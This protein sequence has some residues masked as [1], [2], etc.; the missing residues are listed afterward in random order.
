[1]THAQCSTLNNSRRM[2]KRGPRL[3]ISA[4]PW[5]EAQRLL[6]QYRIT[7]QQIADAAGVPLN[8]A[9]RAL[10][11]ASCGR[12]QYAHVVRV[13]AAAERLLRESG[14]HTA[15]DLWI[16]YDTSLTQGAAA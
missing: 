16:A 4:R 2:G 1:M 11:V 3:P 15:C 8:T 9:N 13:R 5:T 10:N 14:Y 12:C 6:R 7:Q